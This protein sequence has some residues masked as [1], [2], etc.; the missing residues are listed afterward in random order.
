MSGERLDLYIVTG[1]ASGDLHAANLYKELLKRRPGIRCRALGGPRLAAAGCDVPVD[2]TT[3]SIMGVT[4]VLPLLGRFV[5]VVRFFRREL[6][7]LRPKVVVLIDYPGLNFVLARVARSLGIPVAYYICPQVWAWAP[8]RVRK[9]KR[10]ATLRLVIFPFEEPF[11]RD[12][13]GR[14]EYVGHPLCD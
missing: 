1:E 9:I 6:L 13:G 5:S 2:L 12:G 14:C 11:F 4:Q 10:L 8:W 3:F 7:A